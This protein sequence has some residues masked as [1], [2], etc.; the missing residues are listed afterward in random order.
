MLKL[1]TVYKEIMI[2]ELKKSNFK[3]LFDDTHL[4]PWLQYTFLKE[5]MKA[6]VECHN[7]LI[8]SHK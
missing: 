3:H 5:T 2:N 6:M 7:N 8:N 4:M 1:H